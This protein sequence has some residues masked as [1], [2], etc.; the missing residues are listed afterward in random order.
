MNSFVT[1]YIKICKLY[2]EYYEECNTVFLSGEDTLYH[3]DK[4]VIAH[5][6]IHWNMKWK[7]KV[8]QYMKQR[9][10]Q[11]TTEEPSLPNDKKYAIQ[12]L[13]TIQN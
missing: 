2:P 1:Y 11:R 10:S 7:I 3:Y 9:T 4:Q 13:I 6:A 5:N 12:D 8:F